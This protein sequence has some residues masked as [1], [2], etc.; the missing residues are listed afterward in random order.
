MDQLTQALAALLRSHTDLQRVVQDLAG[1]D[2][3]NTRAPGDVLTKLT[4]TDNVEAYLELFERTADRERWPMAE[5]GS[6]LAP[7]LTGEAQQ[8]CSDIPIADARDYG[9]LKEAILASRG[10]SLPARAQRFHSWSFHAEQPPRPQIA[11]LM[12][13]VNGWLGGGGDPPYQERIV[14]D[15][16][17]RALP[18]DARQY[19]SQVSPASVGELTALL[20][21]WQVYKETMKA[22]RTRD[23]RTTRETERA[24]KS[25]RS[26]Q[27]NR[28]AAPERGGRNTGE[29]RCYLCGKTDHISWT[30]PEK[31]R[32]VAMASAATSDG[33]RACLYSNSRGVPSRL[34][35]RVGK[36]DTEALLDS[37]SAVTLVREDLAG[38]LTTDT[39]PVTCVHGDIKTYPVSR[40]RIQTTRG[41]AVVPA[42]VVPNLPVP[43]LIGAD[44]VLFERYWKP[45]G[46]PP[47]KARTAKSDS[48]AA[49]R[50]FPAFRP[51]SDE[52][53]AEAGQPA[54]SGELEDEQVNES[55]DR[56]PG[57]PENGADPFAEFPRP[58]EDREPQRGEFATL[59]WSDPNLAAARG[60][61]SAVDGQLCSGVSAL[62]PPYFVVNKGLVYRGVKDRSGDIV[63]QLLVP[64]AYVSRVLYLA[65]TH[66]L[67]AHLGEKKTY[68]RIVARFY[69]PGIKRAVADFCRACPECQI[70]APRPVQRNPLVPLPIIDV[71]FSR[72]AMDIVGPLPKSARGHRY[73]LVILDYATRYPEAIPLRVAS[74]KAVA[75]ELFMMFSRVGI[76]K[77]ILSD[78]GT[79][80][81]SR[82]LTQLYQWLKI[83]RIRTSAYHPQTDGLTERFNQTLKKMMRK[84]VE[85]DGKDW[86]RLIPYVLFAIREVP[87]ASTGFSPFELVYGRQPRGLL[88][89][90]RETWE[91]QPSPHR[92]VIDHIEQLQARA[93][94]VW[95]MVR[96]HMEEAQSAQA[97]LYNRG[98]KLREF[99]PGEKVLLLV[100]TTECKFLARWQG[101]FE[102]I[103]K[104]SPVNYKVGQPGKRKEQ[105]IYHVNLLKKWHAA[106]SLPAV[107]L[108]CASSPDS[109]PTVPLGEDLTPA[110][111]QDMK[112]LLW[113]NR[114]RFSEI[115]GRTHAIKHDIPTAPGKVVRQRPYR[116]PEA[117]RRAIEQ[118]VT[119]MLKLGVIEESQ[120][121]WSSPIVLVPKPDG[122]I[123]FCNDFRKLNE[124]SAYDSYP[125]QRTDELLER[126]GPARYISTLDLTKGYWQI[127]L[128]E[129]AKEK[130]AFST[131]QGLFHY[132]VLP[133]GVHGAPATFQRLMDRILRPHNAYA[134]SY[135]DD[136]IVH[137][138]DWGQHIKHLEAV[139]AA[140]RDAGLTANARKCRLAAR[141]TEYLGYTVGRGCL[142]P[143][144][145]KV[146][147]VKNWPPPQTKKQ[148]KSFLGL[149]SY[150]QKFINNFSTIA[151]P[152]YDLTRQREPCRIKWSPEAGTAF[153]ALKDALCQSPVL[154]TPDFKKPFLL[155]T[156]ASSTGLGAVLSQAIDGEEH[157]VT[158][159]SRKLMKHEKNYATVEKECLAVKWAIHHL[160][161]YLLGRRFTLI[162]DHAPLKWMAT[163]KDRNAR[164]TRWFLE[165]QNY[166]FDVEHRPGR[167]IPHADALS[168]LYEGLGSE[169]PRPG[170]ELSGGMCGVSPADRRPGK[171]CHPREGQTEGGTA[172]RPLL[173]RVVDGRYVP[174][175]ILEQL[176][177]PHLCGPPTGQ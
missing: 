47:R 21:N 76:A 177:L 116:I 118:E 148:V 131:P 152:L 67:G 32:D 11:A 135:L 97:R 139:M 126:L 60:Q 25:R 24:P 128:T 113:R 138:I 56:D 106:D 8:V 111:L 71:P 174:A 169:V 108:L 112:E 3:N 30:C 18:P 39:M 157:P 87:Q 136:V 168:R 63:E 6:I 46:S 22:S 31:D 2:R 151:A 125:M 37:G 94:T 61:L 75:H 91:S 50:A 68:D 143:Q 62:S 109:L 7:F 150:Y 117:R 147:R 5:W 16:C 146:E 85:I 54:A 145:R 73:I 88:D 41:T 36:V 90:A 171:P 48:T 172:P 43:L 69:W 27:R 159:I 12:R 127:P 141:E 74:A 45:A 105:Q 96:Q 84:L 79:N 110:Q 53:S 9:R 65:H 155:Y 52:T 123:R 44:C 175:V 93:R 163:N 23:E 162:T 101:P 17:I 153:Q 107:A 81:M 38:K 144:T 114:D 124:I 170:V 55:D 57:D 134:A 33:A 119:N 77:E 122:S 66:Q 137:S 40:I 166:C 78:Q 20:E 158:Y 140:L 133:F 28:N 115:P 120:S 149:V 34:P 13:H 130:T 103:E 89:I 156:D 1:R 58:E 129:S 59:Q 132:T 15:K 104:T 80:F 70:N 154:V 121:A 82:L 173:G 26:P 160:R 99:Q 51:P 100:P 35:V 142:K 49:R 161:Y 102:I 176:N 95:P 92:S 72:L 164:V 86:D 10:H 42:G 98:A 19:A 14:I 64:N 4:D 165:L 167:R 29:R 83:K